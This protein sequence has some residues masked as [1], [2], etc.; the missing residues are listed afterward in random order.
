MINLYL[1][2]SK[3]S[4]RFNTVYFYI[5]VCIYLKWVNKEDCVSYHQGQWW[6][7]C[8]ETEIVSEDEEDEAETPEHRQQKWKGKH[9]L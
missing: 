3:Y 4:G 6:V 1:V 7:E 9:V 8:G 2:F 5:L